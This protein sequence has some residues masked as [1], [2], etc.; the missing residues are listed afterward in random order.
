M[1][2]LL[3]ATPATPQLGSLLGSRV[4]RL[5][6]FVV[7]ALGLDYGRALLPLGKEVRTV[8][9]GRR[10][11]RL[12][13]RCAEF[14]RSFRGAAHMARADGDIVDRLERELEAARRDDPMVRARRILAAYTDDGGRNAMRLSHSAFCSSD[15]PKP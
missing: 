1:L 10:D 13:G 5:P 8:R 9:F 2:G 14:V 6:V 3:L 7:G 4:V 12:W 11:G 15:G